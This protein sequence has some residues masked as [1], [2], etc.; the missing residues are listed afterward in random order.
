MPSHIQRA[1][2]LLALIAYSTPSPAAAAEEPSPPLDLYGDPL[3]EFALARLGTVR[4]LPSLD[5]WALSLSADSKTLATG[6]YPGSLDGSVELFEMESGKR[7][8]A[9]LRG[10]DNIIDLAWSPTASRLALSVDGRVGVA[11][12]PDKVEPI[13]WFDLPSTKADS[14]SFWGLQ[15]SPDGKFVAA[16]QIDEPASIHKWNAANGRLVHSWNAADL[17]ADFRPSEAIAFSPS[18]ERLF[19]SGHGDVVVLDAKRA[20]MISHIKNIHGMLDVELPSGAPDVRHLELRGMALDSDGRSLAVGVPVAWLP[21]P[22]E[23]GKVVLWPSRFRIAL[24]DADS[25]RLESTV[26]C[27]EHRALT[28]RFSADGRTLFSKDFNTEIMEWDLKARK[29]LRSF[30]SVWGIGRHMSLSTDGTQLVSGFRRMAI[31]NLK[32]GTLERG[33]PTHRAM[34][35]SVQVTDDGA[36]AVS[37]S[38]D[39]SIQ[40]WDIVTGKHVREIEFPEMAGGRMAMSPSGDLVAAGQRDG[41]I[42][43]LDAVTGRLKGM[44]KGHTAPDPKQWPI[45]AYPPVSGLWFPNDG[46]V[47]FSTGQDAAIRKWNVNSMTE[48]SFSLREGLVHSLSGQGSIGALAV[49]RDG[50]AYA[51]SGATRVVAW[52]GK[53]YNFHEA[54]PALFDT[55]IAVSTDGK[56]LALM[57]VDPDKR[58]RKGAVDLDMI[59]RTRVIDLARGHVHWESESGYMKSAFAFSPNDRI[60][61]VSSYSTKEELM[62]FSAATGKELLRFSGHGDSIRC[63]AFTPDGKRLISGSQ[64]TTLLVWDMTT[65]YERLEEM[66]GKP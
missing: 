12:S 21:S 30:K 32:S 33:L 35:A 13:S 14:P 51:F 63:L 3:P 9:L 53:Q 15:W 28:V 54:E 59:Y 4:F 5:V 41:A 27:G 49:A 60:I 22:I 40:T 24:L 29:A 17:P 38:T 39:G 43:V 44:L 50:T 64:D 37:A 55:P 34:V 26:D 8:R 42:A 18:G 48:V 57:Y 7:T 52:Q 1:L 31:W 61:A 19:V 10:A 23:E 65:A 47:L 56:R 2:L 6:S 46:K 20:G 58:K 25:G 66:E 11:N 62:L 16:V 45:H 36:T